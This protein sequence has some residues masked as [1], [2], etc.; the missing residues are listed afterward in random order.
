MSSWSKL[1]KDIRCL[2]VPELR[3]QIDLHYT[4]YESSSH[5]RNGRG[6]YPSET[7]N[8]RIVV[9]INSE[10]VFASDFWDF[11]NHPDVK[12][13]E[14]NGSEMLQLDEARKLGARQV[15]DYMQALLNYLTIPVSE[16]RTCELPLIR[17]LFYIDR[18]IGKRT[19]AK[20][21]PAED[22]HAL[23]KQCYQL[24]KTVSAK[25]ATA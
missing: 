20:Y 21:P 7:R 6:K 18:R 19:L 23:V 3:R 22:E 8:W 1:R 14:I 15:D 9:T 5:Y 13:R 25:P 16:A 10:E 11:K 12:Q 2:I 24:R 17:A 4:V